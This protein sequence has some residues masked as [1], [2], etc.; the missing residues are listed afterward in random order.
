MQTP[1]HKRLLN[2]AKKLHWWQH[3]FDLDFL[4]VFDSFLKENHCFKRLKSLRIYA[5][6]VTFKKTSATHNELQCSGLAD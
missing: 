1:R 6:T 5:C 3:G 2:I 4:V